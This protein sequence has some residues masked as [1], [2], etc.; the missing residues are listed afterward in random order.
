MS[1]KSKQNISALVKILILFLLV[2]AQSGTDQCQVEQALNDL[3]AKMTGK[4]SRI[5]ASTGQ[6][7]DVYVAN[8]S[9]I[10]GI[11]KT[12]FLSR[13]GE[14]INEAV[15]DGMGLAAKNEPSLKLNV[16]GHIL[17]D[18][19][20]SV[21]TL[22][23]IYFDPGIN[24]DDKFTK[25][26]QGLLDPSSIDILI[27]GVIIDT[28][29]VIRIRPF[30]V[31]KPDKTIKTK[32]LQFANRDELFQNVNGTLSLTVKAHEDIQQAIK[33]ILEEK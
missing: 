9:F 13:E 15:K 8:V 14:L 22:T 20:A 6:G 24:N 31:S 3:I 10:D 19:A 1:K 4:T 28:G 7:T 2:S 27:T 17:P 16:P 23:D 21:I 33:S 11:T 29:G 26:V 18:V 25:I 30:G 32:D 12:G 5:K